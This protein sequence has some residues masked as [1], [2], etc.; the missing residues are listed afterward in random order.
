MEHRH[1][2][3]MTYYTD[4]KY[5]D[6]DFRPMHIFAAYDDVTNQ[7]RGVMVAG[8]DRKC[9]AA[10]RPIP[11]GTPFTIP[12]VVAEMAEA[13]SALR[14]ARYAET[15]ALANAKRVALKALRAGVTERD[16]AIS[17]GVDR[18]TIRKWA[19]KR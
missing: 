16:A 6:D 18:M 4:P 11:P 9:P 13:A 15:E 3:G 14:T 10:M 7:G 17:I 8:Y 1:K 5:T 19:G 2:R 12:K